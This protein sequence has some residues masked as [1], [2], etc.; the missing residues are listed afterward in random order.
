MKKP[1]RVFL[2]VFALCLCLDGL[3]ALGTGVSQAL[4]V[5]EKISP[6]STSITIDDSRQ[7]SIDFELDEPIICNPSSPPPC[8]VVLDFTASIPAGVSV[9]PS[10]LQWAPNEWSVAKTLTFSVTDLGTFT[11][12]QV[13]QLAAIAASGSE[14]YSRYAV[15][16]DLTVL[17]TRTPPTTATSS[18]PVSPAFTG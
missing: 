9:S 2:A 17:G 8:L 14:Y 10:S 5:T 18:D 4:P 13:V 11:S 1:I 6:K 15:T 12:G 16:I 3:G 7:W